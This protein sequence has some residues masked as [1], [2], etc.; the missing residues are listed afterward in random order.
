M[1]S[2]LPSFPT[3]PGS[4]TII[5]PDG[6]EKVEKAEDLPD[7]LKFAPDRSG[8]PAPVVMIARVR[9]GRGFTIR[10]YG[11]DGR[12]LVVTASRDGTPVPPPEL[13][14]GWF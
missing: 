10:S 7:W 4:V 11:P 14:S 6:S 2:Q 9:T 1:T 12:L 8:Q 3:H 13:A 5:S